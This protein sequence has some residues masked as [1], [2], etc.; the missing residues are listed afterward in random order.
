L[1]YNNNFTYNPSSKTLKFSSGATISTT[2]TDTDLTLS[3]KR[4][5]YLTSGSTMYISNADNTPLI[6]RR[7]TT[8]YARFNTKK[9]LVIGGPASGV[10]VNSGISE[11]LY[12]NGTSK[13]LD[14]ITAA[15]QIKTSFKNSI[16]MGS[17]VSAQTTIPNF[18]EEVRYS[19][20]CAG[21]FNLTTAYTLNNITLAIGWYNF[22][23]IPHR[24][25]GINGNASGDNCKYGVLYL[26]RMN[27]N[28]YADYILSYS[29]SAITLLDLHASF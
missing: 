5:A 18:L 24:S 11:K 28:G 10:D 6:F 1:G 3:G 26:H 13:F 21:S 19:S 7:G 29:S 25:G 20:G 23:Y 8:E 14:T 12:V 15:G 17:Y 9:G 2:G 4:Y 16:A 27:A 22:M